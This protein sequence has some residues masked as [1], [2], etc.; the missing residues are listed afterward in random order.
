MKYHD[1]DRWRQNTTPVLKNSEPPLAELSTKDKK[2]DVRKLSSSKIENWYS[3][4]KE[5]KSYG[6]RMGF[7]ADF[8][9][10]I[11]TP[12][13]KEASLKL[14]LKNARFCRVSQCPICTWR[15]SRMWVSKMIKTM[16]SLIE[17]HPNFRFLFLTLTVRNCDIHDLGNTLTDMN[18]AWQR[19]IQ[20]KSFPATGWLRTIEVT[21]GQEKDENGNLRK[22]RAHPHFHC[23]LVVQKSYFKSKKY[24]SK[25]KWID[26]WQKSLRADYEPSVKVKA[27]KQDADPMIL[28][29]EVV[30][31]CTK[32][33]DK[34]SDKEWFFE[35]TRQMHKR[36]TITSGGILRTYLK[37]LEKENIDLIGHE[38]DNVEDEINEGEL[39][40]TWRVKHKQYRMK[41]FN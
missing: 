29:P 34:L 35:L 39:Y 23:I 22:D 4:S 13:K 24:L 2:W 10:F 19:M 5:F 18:K 16:P 32:V 41:V 36:Q 8:L 15:K 37:D 28:V 25:K 14:K 26:L 7:C 20:K 30:K 21:P 11:L 6:I 40:F 17:K 9:Q 33:S 38:E 12:D 27:V 3:S 1:S 31:Y